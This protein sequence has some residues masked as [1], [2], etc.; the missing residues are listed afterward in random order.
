M[1]YSELIPHV[2][3]VNVNSWLCVTVCGCTLYVIQEAK[4]SLR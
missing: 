2:P 4:L 1:A 3:I